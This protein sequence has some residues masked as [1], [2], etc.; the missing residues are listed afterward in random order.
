MK[1]NIFSIYEKIY[2]VLIYFIV[3]VVT[4]GDVFYYFSLNDKSDTFIV[5]ILYAMFLFVVGLHLSYMD[6]KIGDKIYNRR[7]TYVNLLKVQQLLSIADRSSS[8][9][10]RFYNTILLFQLLSGR[11]EQDPSKEEKINSVNPNLQFQD[12]KPLY[13]EENGFVFLD[14]INKVEREYTDLKSRLNEKFNK[15]VS[16]YFEKNNIKLDIIHFYEDNFLYKNY[17]EWCDEH[18][19]EDYET[20]EK[21]KEYIYKVI[22]S[23]KNELNIL[24]TKENNVK[25]YYYK[26]LKKTNQNIKKL[27]SNY[28]NILYL[29]DYN[30]KIN[31]IIECID[32]INLKISNTN[33]LHN[34]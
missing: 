17:D 21:V 33:I 9:P 16:S 32:N 7:N 31:E 12:K 11:T 5:S 26:C 27:E 10:S 18:I 24:E 23:L 4:V 34:D 13:I 20:K 15:A 2:K 1:F 28:G 6:K 30:S 22:E 3:G 14:K 8:N 25:K 29:T 19:Q